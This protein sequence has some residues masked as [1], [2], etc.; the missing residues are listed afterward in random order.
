MEVDQ[1]HEQVHAIC[2][3]ACA[4]NADSKQFPADW[5][6]HRRWGKGREKRNKQQDTDDEAS[7][8][9]HRGPVTTE[10][11]PITFETVGGRTSAVVLALQQP[12][13]VK[14]IKLAKASTVVITTKSKRPASPQIK[15]EIAVM[16][17]KEADTLVS[18]RPKRIK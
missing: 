14:Q 5:L 9:G 10:G 4:V 17:S 15:E 13:S 12:H 7:N 16:T 18:S 3:Q 2:K 11:H 6:F 1:L 8:N